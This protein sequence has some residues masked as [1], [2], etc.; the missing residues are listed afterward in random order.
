MSVKTRLGILWEEQA[1]GSLTIFAL[2]YVRLR[3]IFR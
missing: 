3:R 2:T 1:Q